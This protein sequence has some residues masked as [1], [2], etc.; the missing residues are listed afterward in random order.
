MG[1]GKVALS[2]CSDDLV[3]SVITSGKKLHPC[4]ER[5]IYWTLY[6]HPSY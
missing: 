1:I 3:S 4:I 5:H 2:S 6:H